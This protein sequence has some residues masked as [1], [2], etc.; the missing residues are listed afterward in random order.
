MN[1]DG[2][3]VFDQDAG[4]RA[5]PDADH[6]GHRRGKPKRARTRDDQ[7]RDGVDDG[8]GKARLWTN[9]RQTIKVMTAMPITAGTK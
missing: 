4:L 7:H 1:F 8:M 9:E 5:A 6:D 3:G 2:F